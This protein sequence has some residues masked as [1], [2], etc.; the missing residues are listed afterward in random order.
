MSQLDYLLSP[1]SLMEMVRQRGP[2]G[3]F[4]PFTK[5]FKMGKAPRIEGGGKRV[6]FEKRQYDQSLAG[7][8]TIGSEPFR[9]AKVNRKV[10][11]Q[12]FIHLSASDILGPEDLFEQVGLGELGNPDFAPEDL[13]ADKLAELMGTVFLAAE[14]A[15]SEFLTNA[16]GLSLTSSN[17]AF[18]TGA[19]KVN[20]T[21]TI[22]GSLQTSA[23]TAKWSNSA[24]KFISDATNTQLPSAMRTLEA[25]GH[26]PYRMIHSRK[27]AAAVVGNTE[28]AQWLTTLGGQTIEFFKGALNAASAGGVPYEDPFRPNVLSG[29]GDVPL[30]HTWDHGY[31][32]RSGTFTRFMPD[33]AALLLPERID[34]VLG[35]AEG[36][37]AIPNGPDVYG[38]EQAKELIKPVKGMT[39]FA[40]RQGGSTPKIELVVRYAFAPVVRD[41][42]GVLLLTNVT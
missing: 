21:A 4:G 25:N 1:H 6:I 34:Q 23:Q 5:L 3:D 12:G 28:A 24:T 10:V 29:I 8:G 22:D 20:V 36:Y 9:K 41:E 18:P 39:A 7:V 15:C 32:N 14:Y 33:T 27:V 13:I 31:R 38:A 16:S 30:W 2:Q 35:F 17:T 37:S 19:C 42:L 11:E 26:R 40:V